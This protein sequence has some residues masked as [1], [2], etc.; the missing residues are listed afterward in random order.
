V[1]ACRPDLAARNPAEAARS[2]AERGERRLHLPDRLA[3]RPK[4]AAEALG[5]SE[6][7]LRDELNQIPHVRLGEQ[8]KVAR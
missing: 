7:K 2:K 4:E 5:I 6:R 1:T 8:L 3:L